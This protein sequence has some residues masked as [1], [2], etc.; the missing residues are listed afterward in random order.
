MS[1]FL[2]GLIWV[3]TGYKEHRYMTKVTTSGEKELMAIRIL[4]CSQK[5]GILS[6]SGMLRLVTWGYFL[7]HFAIV[8]FSLVL[9]H[10]YSVKMTLRPSITTTDPL[11][12]DH[13]QPK[14]RQHTLTITNTMPDSPTL[15]N[16]LDGRQSKTLLPVTVDERGSKIARNSIF[17]CHLSPVR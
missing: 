14:Q 16:T 1:D 5:V 6:A 11:H 3:Q 7:I 17:D 13:K 9:Y 15:I 8:A 2:S 10:F 12:I 4:Y